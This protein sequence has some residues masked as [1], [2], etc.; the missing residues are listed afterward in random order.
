MRPKLLVVARFGWML[1]R[2]RQLADLRSVLD[3]AA[4]GL[5]IDELVVREI[6]AHLGLLP[7]LSPHEPSW[8]AT[9]ID[10]DLQPIV[11]NERRKRAHLIRN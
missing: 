4:G 10:L 8:R 5:I 3:R 9:L 2:T 1:A 6:A 11:E 7:L